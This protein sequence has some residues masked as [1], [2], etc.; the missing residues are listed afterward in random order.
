[1]MALGLVVSDKK[2]FFMFSLYMFLKRLSLGSKECT[3]ELK[4]ECANVLGQTS[5]MLIRPFRPHQ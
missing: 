4:P 5:Y 3:K 2:I 1:M